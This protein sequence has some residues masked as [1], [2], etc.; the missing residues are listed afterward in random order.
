MR[1]VATTATDATTDTTT[2]VTGSGVAS[3]VGDRVRRPGCCVNES[4]NS[5]A[6]GPVGVTVKSSGKGP[7]DEIAK[8]VNCAGQDGT[9]FAV[10]V[11]LRTVHPA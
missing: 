11:V 7:G 1:D 2:M 6:K 8:Y 3:R 5:L 10:G 9:L 4:V